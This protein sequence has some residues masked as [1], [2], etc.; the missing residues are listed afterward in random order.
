M[1]MG[2]WVVGT[3]H[4]LFLRGFHIKIKKK[5]KTSKKIKKTQFAKT[6]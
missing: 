3:L 1:N 6:T 4:E 5:K 2:N